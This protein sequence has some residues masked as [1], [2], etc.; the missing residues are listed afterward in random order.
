[1]VY[2]LQATKNSDKSV[3][4]WVIWGYEKEPSVI[5]H[6]IHSMSKSSECPYAIDNIPKLGCH[7]EG[8]G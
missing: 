2:S 1:M 4:F 7:G 6:D 8:G 5:G 3:I